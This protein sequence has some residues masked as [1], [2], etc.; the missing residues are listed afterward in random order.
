MKSNKGITLI[1][2]VITIIILIILAGISISM[3]AGEN[4]IISNA[5]LAQKE[6]ERAS[7]IE[8][9]QI[10]ILEKQLDGT[11][12]GG[13]L[14]DI[15]N[16]YEDQMN[17]LDVT[18]D[19]VVGSDILNKDLTVDGSWL[20][21]VNAP[22]LGEG[23]IPV[24]WNEENTEYI[25][26]V[27]SEWHLYADTTISGKDT[28]KWANA[29]NEDG[30]YF[31]WIPRYEYKIDEENQT[32]DIKFIETDQTEPSEGYIIHPVFQDGT[33]NNFQN[34][35]W[36][37]EISGIW[38]MKFE[39]S[40]NTN[41]LLESV[42]NA[43]PLRSINIGDMYTKAYDYDREDESHLTK[44][45]EWGAI[46]YLTYSEYGRDGEIL[47]V[48]NKLETG[49][50]N[51]LENTKQSSTGN[52]T[53]IY[54]LRGGA[55]EYVTAYTMTGHSTLTTNAGSFAKSEVNSKGY[56]TEST[57][58]VTV[59]P[60]SHGEYQNLSS[61]TYGYGDAVLETSTVSGSWNSNFSF[62]PVSNLP[63]FIRGGDAYD[64]TK[65]GIFAYSNIDGKATSHYGFRLILIP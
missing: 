36:D 22:K 17:D 2:L 63:F 59:Y 16:K 32:I 43:S 39:A 13:T 47:E 30:S 37:E 54:D 12:T 6:I 19:D 55:W 1:S 46:A 5:N 24:T 14:N 15:Y 33:D 35:E 27:D 26:L 10:E 18:E 23:M 9:I 48:N 25:P 62:Y 60:F 52:V 28:S 44:N 34:G 20:G 61:N 40:Q 31:V 57:K 8:E 41:N 29:K 3:I 7:L 50:N 53:G 49:G 64:G 4:G 51:Y 58:Y 65:T 11:L 42:S 38:V 21:Y 56:M 45:S